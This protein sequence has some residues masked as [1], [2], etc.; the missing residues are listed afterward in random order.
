MLRFDEYV[1]MVACVRDG[2]SGVGVEIGRI[3]KRLE[4]EFPGS[5]AYKYSLLLLLL[6][7]VRLTGLSFLAT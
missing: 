7:G 3:V 5:C 2:C 1:C 6:P 4:Q